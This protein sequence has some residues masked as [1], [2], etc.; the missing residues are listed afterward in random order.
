MNTVA[1]FEKVNYDT[2]YLGTGNARGNPYQNGEEIHKVYDELKIPQRS[3]DGSAGYDFFAPYKIKIPYGKSVIIP[4]GIKA[5]IE[6]GWFL[7]LFPRSG[8]GFK[9][10]IEIA[11]TVGIIDADYYNNTN[12]EGHIM[13]KLTNK[14]IS[15]Q[16]TFEVETGQAFCQGIFLPF[17]ITEDDDQSSK[18]VREGGFGSTDKS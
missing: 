4:T 14:D 1:K 2:F 10:G 8:H 12:N 11:N 5:R 3:T 17:G 6:D 13:V 15:T 18:S 9:F 7:A 16:K